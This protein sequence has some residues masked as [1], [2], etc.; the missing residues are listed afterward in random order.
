MQKII[1]IL[2]FIT[3]A[4]SSCFKDE[5]NY[6]YH[7][8]NEVEISGLPEEARIYYRNVDT[9]KASPIVKG[10]LDAGDQSRY[11]YTWKAVSKSV[12]GSASESY[13]IGT[14]KELD[15]FVV[16][17]DNDYDIYCCVKDTLTRVTWDSS[18]PITVTTELNAGWLVLSE[19]A[20]TCKLDL[21]SL[22]A[23]Q[24]M[25]VRDVMQGLPRLA[26]PK[27]LQCCYNMAREQFGTEPRFYLMSGDGCYKLNVS[28]YQ[29]DETGD[30]LY[31]MMEYPEG[32]APAV[33]AAG[34]GW[35]LVIAEKMAYGIY[36][37][38]SAPRPFGL[39]CNHLTNSEEYFD[40][41]EAV[42][43]YPY[44][45]VYGGAKILYDMTNSR[46]VKLAA[47]M[48]SCEEIVAEAPYFPWTTGK[49]FVY[50]GSTPYD[51][52]SV[53]AILKD[54]STGKLS[55]YMMS[56]NTGI[57][58]RDCKEL[59]AAPGIAQA[60]CFAVYPNSNWLFY[61]VGNKVYQYDMN[62]HSVEVVAFMDEIVTFL[63]F[64]IFTTLTPNDDVQRQL[65]IGTVGASTGDLNG[66]MYFY[67]V[68]TI[69]GE[70][71]ELLG[72]YASFGK[73]VDAIYVEN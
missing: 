22:S 37:P 7:E 49:E 34:Y 8:I 55:M 19:A 2:A 39:P 67:K 71:F 53:Y 50:M 24:N 59:D 51:G 52:G 6:V 38:Y 62:G 31:E 21:I 30:L 27:A 61:A 41:A 64:N 14:E 48:L 32:Y 63:K 58:Q 5:G 69:W 57:I 54:P 65:V 73:P 28:D 23:K 26:N 4:F 70:A 56:V 36:A 10:N 46:F 43:Y 40:V 44:Y 42:G 13:I 68:P 18:F 60:T 11:Y 1:F 12:P 29:W 66:Q 35:E 25:V 45:F 47:D 72:S 17:P 20:D 9:L 15:Y 33:K 16:L 3:I